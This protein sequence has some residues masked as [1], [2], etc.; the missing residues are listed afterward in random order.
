MQFHPGN[1]VK[2]GETRGGGRTVFTGLVN[3]GKSRSKTYG[4]ALRRPAANSIAGKLRWDEIA[5]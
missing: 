3:S 2:G 4:R 5:L 1:P